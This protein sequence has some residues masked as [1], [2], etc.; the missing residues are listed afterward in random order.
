MKRMYLRCVIYQGIRRRRRSMKV[1][2]ITPTPLLNKFAVKSKYHL[3]LAHEYVKDEA[4]RQFYKER[5]KAGD[6]VML[7]NGAY[8]LG[9]SIPIRELY[10]IASDLNPTA[11]FLPDA[12]FQTE[13][14][15]QL[16][17]EALQFL[18]GSPWQL[19]GIPQGD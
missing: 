6:Y 16:V 4:Y 11:I 19:I 12:R 9:E 1:A 2:L 10:D 15:M 18:H 8:E 7:D 14:T 13:R 3:V 5:S 17:T